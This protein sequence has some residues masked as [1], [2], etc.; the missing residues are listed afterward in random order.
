MDIW[1]D[2]LLLYS[3]LRSYTQIHIQFYCTLDPQQAFPEQIS[4]TPFPTPLTA[5]TSQP[6]HFTFPPSS[7]VPP[8]ELSL[9]LDSL[10]SYGT[11]R[12][13]TLHTL[14]FY[15]DRLVG[16]FPVHYFHTYDQLVMSHHAET[17]WNQ[18]GNSEKPRIPFAPKSI[19]LEPLPVETTPHIREHPRTLSLTLEL[20]QRHCL[21][22]SAP[23]TTH[24]PRKPVNRPDGFI[25]LYERG[26]LANTLRQCCRFYADYV[27]D[28]DTMMELSASVDTEINQLMKETSSPATITTTTTNTLEASQSETEV[29]TS[30]NQGS[31]DGHTE[32]EDEVT[33]L[34]DFSLDID[35]DGSWLNTLRQSSDNTTVELIKKFQASLPKSMLRRS[36][37]PLTWSELFQILSPVQQDTRY[38][39]SSTPSP[40]P[41][42]TLL[43]GQDSD[44]VEVSP[45]D[46]INWDKLSLCPYGPREDINFLV[47]SP[48]GEKL[49]HRVSCL[50]F[51]LF[52]RLFFCLFIYLF[53]CLFLFVYLFLFFLFFCLFI[54]LFICLFIYLLFYLLACLFVCLSLCLYNQVSHY[55]K[56]LSQVYQDSELGRHTLVSQTNSRSDGIY[57]YTPAHTTSSLYLDVDSLSVLKHILISQVL[58]QLASIS[59]PQDKQHKDV[60]LFQNTTPQHNH[61]LYSSSPI[62]ETE[63]PP[64]VVL[65]ILNTGAPHQQI[66]IMRVFAEALVEVSYICYISQ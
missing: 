53:F 14:E 65:Y 66:D 46:V 28:E 50:F 1:S 12:D 56:Q 13:L 16:N 49:E 32:D 25:D 2:E 48:V 34:V 22:S 30:Q 51:C 8:D 20:I 24:R 39:T 38:H 41:V 5:H 11:S 44:W 10:L 23:L 40:L 36:P 42:P 35:N 3:T 6:N 18:V 47:I 19:Q 52:F 4:A 59:S 9:S 45:Y 64:S 60:E 63:R 62:S 58:S 61:N 27:E 17:G 43:A 57:T 55:F 37:S 7:Y 15:E 21:S 29:D 26:T 33:I 54:Y 31:E